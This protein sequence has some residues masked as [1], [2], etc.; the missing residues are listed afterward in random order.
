MYETP[1]GLRIWQIVAL[2]VIF[3]MALGS[4]GYALG[5]CLGRE[6]ALARMCEGER[7]GVL[8]VPTTSCD[9]DV[10]QGLN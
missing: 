8:L 3:G 4:L 6:L 10:S 1:F 9:S 7:V 5:S 2:L